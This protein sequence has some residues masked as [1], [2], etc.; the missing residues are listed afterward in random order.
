MPAF[1]EFYSKQGSVFIG[2]NKMVVANGKLHSLQKRIFSS[3]EV[4][5]GFRFCIIF[6]RRI[7]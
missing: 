3:F 6:F 1:L 7:L 4:L 5:R 2:W